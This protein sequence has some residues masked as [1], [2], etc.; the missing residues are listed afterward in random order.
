MSDVK[1]LIGKKDHM[2]P[3]TEKYFYFSFVPI[4][5]VVIKFYHVV[6]EE[7]LKKVWIQYIKELVVYWMRSVNNQRVPHPVPCHS[8]LYYGA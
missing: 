7:G 3:K 2:V 6:L 8:P 1:Y 4:C 5:I